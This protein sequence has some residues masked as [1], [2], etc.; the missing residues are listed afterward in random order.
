MALR[1]IGTRT[2]DGGEFCPEGLGRGASGARKD[3]TGLLARGS[4]MLEADITPAQHPVNL[5]RFAALNPWASGLN[6]CLEPDGTLRLM[7]RQGD[8]HLETA[9]KTTIGTLAVTVH[10]T[11]TWDAPARRGDLS[12]YLPDYGKLWRVDVRQPFP[13]AMRDAERMMCAPDACVTDRSVV[14]AA[15]ADAPCPHGPM[16]GLSGNAAID[17]PDGPR[18]LRDIVAGDL[19]NA[20]APN[21]TR[22][23][24]VLWAGRAC[25]PTLGRFAPM[26][27]RQP[28]LGLWDDLQTT[29]DQRICMAGSEV[30]YMFGEERVSTAVRYL[31]ER[32]CA[33]PTRNNPATMHFYQL[34]LETH[35]IITVNGAEVE[36]FDASAVLDDPQALHASVLADLPQATRPRRLGLAAPVLRGFEALTLTGVSIG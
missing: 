22:P 25:L 17:T 26:T 35:E 4:L 3:N 31:L 32:N 30:E 21:G 15:I 34:L 29:Q 20:A 19:V 14:F 6:I 18:M 9:L 23:M 11:F 13:L 8:R 10:I 12:L 1:W 24:R 2:R 36:S 16:P 33:A 7:I 5:L 28:Y 27:L